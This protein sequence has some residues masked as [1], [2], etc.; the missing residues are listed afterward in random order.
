MTTFFS[1][2]ASVGVSSF[3]DTAFRALRTVSLSAELCTNGVTFCAP[4]TF[5]GS[6]RTTKL[7]AMIAGSVVNRSAACTS[8]FFSAATV[9]GPP[10]SSDLNC[11]KFSP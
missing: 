10:V 8:P 7:L 9:S 11:L 3:A 4:N 6:S 1:R 5:F 2:S